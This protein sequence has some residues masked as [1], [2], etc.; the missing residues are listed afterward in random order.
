MATD[1]AFEAGGDAFPCVNDIQRD[2]FF[3]FLRE[4]H[5]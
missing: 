1:L 4:R 3:S 2:L 5:K